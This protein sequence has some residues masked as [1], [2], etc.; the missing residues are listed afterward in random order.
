LITIT[1]YTAQPYTARLCSGVPYGTQ[2]ANAVGSTQRLDIY[3]PLNDPP[4]GGKFPV[5]VWIHGGAWVGFDRILDRNNDRNISLAEDYQGVLR[6][7]TRG[8]TVVSVD[9]RL[10]PAVHFPQPLLDVKQA[11]RWVKSQATAWK[12][13]PEK[14]AAGGHS[15]GA[16]LAALTGGTAEAGY[17]EP[18]PATLTGQFEP[19]RSQNSKTALTIGF[20]GPY[21]FLNDLSNSLVRVAQSHFLGCDMPGTD[22]PEY[23]TQCPALLLAAAS[24]AAFPVGPPVYLLHS[25]GDR[26]VDYDQALDYKAALDNASRP[27]ALKTLAIEADHGGETGNPAHWNYCRAGDCLQQEVDF[28][29]YAF[30]NGPAP[31]TPYPY[32]I[33]FP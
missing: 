5:Y 8:F 14:I 15:A 17:F 23:P 18:D 30:A 4:N 11:V 2:N 7:I 32:T 20:S 25:P 12:L 28:L 26:V 13:N 16:H 24:P 19:L 22:V 3:R 21:N 31:G 33:P 10:A 6:Q 1:G 29:L 27:V 9:Y